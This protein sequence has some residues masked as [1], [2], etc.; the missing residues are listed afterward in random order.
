[1]ATFSAEFFRFVD[2]LFTP[3]TVCEG[4]DHLAA[5]LS[6]EFLLLVS[7]ASALDAFRRYLFTFDDGFIAAFS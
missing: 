6:T 5:A 1:M 2:G 7:S 4:N 3:W